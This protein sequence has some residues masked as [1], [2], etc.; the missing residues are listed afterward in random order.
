MR[1]LLSLYG[2]YLRLALVASRRTPV[3]TALVIVAVAVG[4][5]AS[6]TVYTTFR[7]MAGDPIPGKSERLFVVQIENRAPID[8]HDSSEL[9]DHLTFKDALALLR[10]SD[11]PSQLAQVA[12]FPARAI[13]QPPPGQ[14]APAF[15]VDVRATTPSFFRVF[16]VP[17]RF[18]GGWAVADEEARAN[19]AVLGA[20]IN[21][22]LFGGE[23]SVG[24]T[25]NLAG[26][27]YRIVGVLQP[28]SPMPRF[29]DVVNGPFRQT[30][31]VFLPLATA[32]DR[33]IPGTGRVAC[34]QPYGSGRSA[35]LDSE[36]TWIQ[37]WVDLPT[38][39]DVTNYG[40]RLEQYALE[41]H[42]AGRFSWR[43]STRLRNVRQ[44]L[45]QQRVVPNEFQIA[46][47]L[48]FAFLAVCLI[49][50][51]GLILAKFG[52]RS[53]EFG[54]RRA[55][56]A[57]RSDLLAQCIMESAA[58]GALGGVVGLLLTY[59]GLAL[60]RRILPPELRNLASLDSTT[61]LATVIVAIV[62]TVL[63]GLYPAWRAS[64]TQP[65]WELKS[66]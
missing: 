64:R 10:L 27:D 3:L 51:V 9:P 58:A 8:R 50:A 14:L 36:C 42:S 60:E 6:M 23:N 56:G 24:R 62:A 33:E 19:V 48:A 29:Y 17:F 18:G 55:L 44:W 11:P 38:A 26:R 57:S 63:T 41:Q 22:R 16:D 25:V 30:E 2:H 28:W 46:V 47:L 53:G 65:A 20:K 35:F 39:S 7:A 5:G 34:T 1:Q 49:N 54:V 43:P 37:F 21:A 45:V 13:V 31:D 15:H 12:M 32:I 40:R 59:L 4:I 66:R 52:S 61:M